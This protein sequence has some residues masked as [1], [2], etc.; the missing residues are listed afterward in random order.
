MRARYF[1]NHL[2]PGSPPNVVLTTLSPAPKNWRQTLQRTSISLSGRMI[3]IHG[4]DLSH[5]TTPSPSDPRRQ[6][7]KSRYVFQYDRMPRHGYCM[8]E[9][10][11]LAHHNIYYAGLL[12]SGIEVMH[13]ALLWS[14]LVMATGRYFSRLPIPRPFKSMDNKSLL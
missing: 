3:T 2:I 7:D 1:S 14:N 4:R 5:R 12:W 13:V 8:W 6:K 10:V 9:E 11:D